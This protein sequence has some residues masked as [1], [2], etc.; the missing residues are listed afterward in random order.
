MSY[1]TPTNS[2]WIV[3]RNEVMVK[4]SSKAF[5]IS[6]G[7]TLGMI[8]L[9]FGASL[10]FGQN[11]G[12]DKI[13]VADSASRDVVTMAEGDYEVIEVSADELGATVE[14]GDADAGLR[15][16]ETWELLV[17]DPVELP[18]QLIETISAYQLNQNLIELDLDP[19]LVLA[20]T[21]PEIISVGDEDASDAITTMIVSMVFAVLFFMSALIYGLQIAQSVV[22]EKESRIVEILTAAVPTR[23]LLTGKVVGNTLMALGQLTLYLAVGLVGLS[24]SEWADL[25]PVVVPNVA[26]F[27]VFFLFGFAALACL[28]AATGAMATRVQDLNNT[29]TPLTM[30]LTA[31]Y[32]AG[33][34]ASGTTA[35]VLSYVPIVSSVVMPARLLEGDAT[36]IE[37]VISLAIV[38]AFMVLAI[39]VGSAIYRRG[40]MQTSSVMKLSEVFG[41][42]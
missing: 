5:W 24:L 17:A 16:G 12:T 3:A 34:M 42:S 4:I 33:F 18:T 35:Q 36:W 13:A 37:A 25:V 21:Q 39:R 19:T 9:A 10:I 31:A 23:Q 22:E 26:W 29:T 1:Q 7:V 40:I 14:A 8:L 38:M 6:T 11:A 30:L 27:I 15:H 28:W 20:N 41:K 2:W 32:I